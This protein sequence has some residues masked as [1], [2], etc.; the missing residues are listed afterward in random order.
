MSDFLE[1]KR[2]E[3]GDRLRELAPLVEEY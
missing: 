1:Q 3:I 2:N